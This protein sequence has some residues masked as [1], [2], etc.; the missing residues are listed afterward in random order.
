MAEDVVKR[1]YITVGML[2]LLTLIPLALTSTTGMIR[3]LG[4]RRWTRLHRLVYLTRVLAALHF[5]LLAQGGRT[6]Q[7]VYAAVLALL[8]RVRVVGWARRLAP[9]ARAN[10]HS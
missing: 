10:S 9:R 5:I 6:D 1:P 4:A 2:A 8:L 3:R 7:Y